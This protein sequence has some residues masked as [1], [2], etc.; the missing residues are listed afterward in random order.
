MLAEL[1]LAATVGVSVPLAE[2]LLELVPVATGV[3]V[4]GP[5]EL[6]P[7]ELLP[8]FANEK[9]CQGIK[10]WF[11]EVAE[12]ALAVI[13][14]V[15]VLLALLEPALFLADGVPVPLAE[16]PFDELLLELLPLKLTTT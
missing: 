8:A 10:T 13:E 1:L 14:G 7:E 5:D 6:A 15:P 12:P 16:A 11:F 9:A 2:E 3:S 4:A